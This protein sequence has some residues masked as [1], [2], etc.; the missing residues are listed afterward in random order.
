MK[1]LEKILD[2]LQEGKIGKVEAMKLIEA[3]YET[4]ANDTQERG[5]KVRI[6]VLENG[7]KKVS[8]NLPLSLLRFFTKT[9]KLL[10]KNYIEVEGETIP[11]DIEELEKVLSDPD[12]KG[13]ILNVDSEMDQDGKNVKVMI[14]VL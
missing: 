1:E 12:F 8:V 3:L 13:P 14:E 2:L 5:R 9:T 6:E 11:I 10:N 7:A 4:K